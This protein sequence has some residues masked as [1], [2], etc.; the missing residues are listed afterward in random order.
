MDLNT[1]SLA[2][3]SVDPCWAKICKLKFVKDYLQEFETAECYGIWSGS[4]ARI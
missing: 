3:S 2:M 1:C 4:F